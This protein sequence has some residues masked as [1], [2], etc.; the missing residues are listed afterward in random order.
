MPTF[1]LVYGVRQPFAAF[2][3]HL[4]RNEPYGMVIRF[5][6]GIEAT[7]LHNDDLRNAFIVWPIFTSVIPEPLR[8]WRRLFAGRCFPVGIWSPMTRGFDFG[9]VPKTE[10]RLN[11]SL[12][13]M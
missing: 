12:V 2:P 9:R 8:M 10:K 7:L 1:P 11:P 13:S 6:L 4:A 5:P 3:P